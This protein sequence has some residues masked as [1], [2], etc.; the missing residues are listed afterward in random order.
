MNKIV[1]KKNFINF[2][3]LDYT[4][5][6]LCSEGY[7]IKKFTTDRFGFRNPD[8]LWDQ[9]IDTVIIGDSFVEGQCV[10]YNQSL[11]GILE[12]YHWYWW[13]SFPWI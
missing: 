11:S 9:N 8:Y 2:S 10:D 4:N 7:G 3:S 5:F 12:S 13:Y 6:I 1:K